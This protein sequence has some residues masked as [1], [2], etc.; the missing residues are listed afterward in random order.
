M[1][2][3]V[4]FLL[5]SDLVIR[6]L[7]V[8]SNRGPKVYVGAVPGDRDPFLTESGLFLSHLQILRFYSSIPL[9]LCNLFTFIIWPI[10]LKELC[11]PY[12]V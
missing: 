11:T 6:S 2:V 9:S 5:C 3:C 10:R 12:L 4:G 1:S 8:R 7:S